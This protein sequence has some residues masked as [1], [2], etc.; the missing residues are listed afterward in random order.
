[1]INLNKILLQLRDPS[2]PLLVKMR[3]KAPWTYYHS[4][5][6]GEVASFACN[7]FKDANPLL[8]LVWARFHDIW[9][10]IQPFAYAENQEDW[11]YPFMPEIIKT[12]VKNWI[13]MAK[14]YNLP[15]AVIRF[16]ITHHGTA[17]APAEQWETSLCYDM[18][19]NP[20]TVEETLVML[21]D[22]CE[23]AVR[24]Y[25]WVY[26]KDNLR[27]VIQ[28]VFLKKEQDDQ[29]LSSVLIAADFKQ[30]EDDFTDSFY[31]VHHRRFATEQ[32]EVTKEWFLIK[33]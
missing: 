18:S 12:H 27:K 26:S 6:V 29:L 23:A 31:F 30:V 24:W 17:L 22:S 16:I 19:E 11:D 4:L 21:A 9:K 5:L 8:A 32:K 25:R 3:Q 1:M 33:A 28:G 7:N 2:H 15:D 20:V 13:S 10:M 14:A